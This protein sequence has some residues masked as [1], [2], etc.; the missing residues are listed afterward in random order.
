MYQCVWLAG[1]LHTFFA[2]SIKAQLENM[3]KDLLR[4]CGTK[5]IA[6]TYMWDLGYDEF[7]FVVR[8]NSGTMNGKGWH[9]SHGS[10]CCGAY[11]I[12]CRH[13]TLRH[14]YTFDAMK[15]NRLIV[16]TIYHLIQMYSNHIY[17]R[18]KY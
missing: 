1:W 8:Q 13:H 3:I 6:Y 11:I 2:L 9:L 15:K 10:K 7:Y 4:V 17:I 14:Y 18:L 5:K 16:E 12:L